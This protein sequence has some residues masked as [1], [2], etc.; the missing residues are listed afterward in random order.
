MNTDMKR[1]VQKT[2]DELLSEHLIPFALT[3]QKINEEEP[4]HYFVPFFDSRIHS[5]RFLWKDR[6][7]S[8]PEIIRIAVLDRV[9]GISRPPRDWLRLPNVESKPLHT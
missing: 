4:G 1:T 8:L 3:A 9:K 6:A 2:L 5:F 7:S